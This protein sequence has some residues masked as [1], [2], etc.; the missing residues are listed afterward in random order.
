MTTNLERSQISEESTAVPYGANFSELKT[1]GYRSLIRWVLSVS[2]TIGNT[3][4]DY[5]S[6][7]YYMMLAV[8]HAALVV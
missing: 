2:V 6:R 3:V 1:L 7:F 4:V 8:K 5:E